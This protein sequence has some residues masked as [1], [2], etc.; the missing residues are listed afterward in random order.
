MKLWYG[1]LLL[2]ALGLSACA[3]GETEPK[4]PVIR[5][6]E[7]LCAE[8]N[9]I[10]NDPRYAAGYAYEVGPGRYESLAFDDIGDLLTHMAKHNDHTVVA[11]YVHDYTSEEWLDATA[12]HYVV[13]AA[14]HTPMG[15]GIAAHA[16]ATAAMSMAQER[17]GQVLDWPTL[18][19]QTVAGTLHE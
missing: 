3:R 15:H 2:V 1:W 7:A 16:T 12:A 4:P 6:G 17:Q 8:C 9:M 11:W 13:S 10:I 19:A 5:Y 18:V 14:I